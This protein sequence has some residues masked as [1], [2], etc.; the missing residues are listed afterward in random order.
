M[1]DGL[2][3]FLLPSLGEGGRE[4][5]SRARPLGSQLMSIKRVIDKALKR[6]IK[7]E[8]ELVPQKLGIELSAQVEF[9]CTI[10]PQVSR[11]LLCLSTNRV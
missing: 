4:Q 8:R 7:E 5:R 3:F 6:K 1:H 2:L 11:P 10:L 9:G